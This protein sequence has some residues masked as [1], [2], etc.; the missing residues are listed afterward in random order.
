[1]RLW[2]KYGE[3]TE[4]KTD[5]RKDAES[6]ITRLAIALWNA[7]SDRHGEQ[8]MGPSPIMASR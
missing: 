7:V 5:A 2:Q 6:A 4:D 1:M 8:L 3:K